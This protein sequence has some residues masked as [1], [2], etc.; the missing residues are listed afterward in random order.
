MFFSGGGTWISRGGELALVGGLPPPSVGGGG[1]FPNQNG[2]WGG[3]SPLPP[4]YS[5]LTVT[6]TAM[7]FSITNKLNFDLSAPLDTESHW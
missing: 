7:S 5:P 2:F 6:T 3:N 4:L 1:K